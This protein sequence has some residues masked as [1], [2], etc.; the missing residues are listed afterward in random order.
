[1]APGSAP[2]LAAAAGII[3]SV[4]SQAMMQRM[5]AAAIRQ[6]A[7]R[8]AHDNTVTKAERDVWRTVSERRADDLQEIRRQ[9]ACLRLFD[10]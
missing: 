1:M 2:F 4:K 10:L 8:V 9:N 7:A 6:E 5:I 3:A